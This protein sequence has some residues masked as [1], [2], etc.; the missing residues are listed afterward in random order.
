VT[1]FNILLKFLL[2]FKN[3][4]VLFGK[5]SPL[6]LGLAPNNSFD[7]FYSIMII[8]LINKVF[9][10][11]YIFYSNFIMELNIVAIIFSNNEIHPRNS[12]QQQ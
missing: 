10:N 4:I 11:N 6:L 2:C 12:K 3:I 8:I 5:L 9:L 1:I 7:A